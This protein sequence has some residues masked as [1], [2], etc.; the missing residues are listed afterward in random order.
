MLLQLA[1]QEEMEG[2]HVKKSD[3]VC[4]INAAN[5]SV[6]NEHTIAYIQGWIRGNRA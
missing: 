1:I 5:K 3:R 4:M 6:H 2:V